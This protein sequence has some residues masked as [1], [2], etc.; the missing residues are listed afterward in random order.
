[1][2]DGVCIENCGEEAD[3]M[4][5]CTSEYMGKNCTVMVSVRGIRIFG[6]GLVCN[7]VLTETCQR[8]RRVPEEVL[9]A[10]KVRSL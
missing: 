5:N 10:S 3:Y 2:N 4:C 7:L 9:N 1:M 8:C 6:V